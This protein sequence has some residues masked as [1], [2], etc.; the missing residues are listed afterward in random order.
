MQMPF[1]VIYAF[2]CALKF[3]K[4][5]QY[6]HQRTDKTTPIKTSTDRQN[7]TNK[8]I[9]RSTLFCLSVD[10]VIGVGLSVC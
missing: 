3:A 6:K 2:P 1:L 8:N 7:N 4:Q 5:H 10:V 9:N